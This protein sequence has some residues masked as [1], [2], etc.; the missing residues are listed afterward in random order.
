MQLKGCSPRSITNHRVGDERA[1]GTIGD[2]IFCPFTVIIDTREQMSFSFMG[3]NVVKGQ[4][5]HPLLVKTAS[6]TLA[7]GDYS[8]LGYSD[9]ISIERKSL[10]DLYSTLTHGRERFERELTRLQEMQFSVVIVE[11]SLETI[12]SRPPPNTR[13]V[14]KSIYSSIIAYQQRFQRTHWVLCDSRRLAE[15]TAFRILERYWID[16]VEKPAKDLQRQQ[17]L[18][19]KNGVS[20]SVNNGKQV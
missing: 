19:K 4:T 1:A 18:Q 16:N 10:E 9:K 15:K 14:P 20:D 11:A 13:V 8:I 17:R 12:I 6:M 2:L 5:R 7:S 3:M